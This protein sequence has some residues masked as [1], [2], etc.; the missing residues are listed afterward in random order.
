MCITYT[1]L[2]IN[3]TIFV[4]VEG[5]KNV[6][7]KLLGI[8]R[9]EEHFVHVHEFGRRQAAVGTILLQ[10]GTNKKHKTK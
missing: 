5:A 1:H 8:S 3:I 6:I 9:W 2:K 10:C 4:H 7:T